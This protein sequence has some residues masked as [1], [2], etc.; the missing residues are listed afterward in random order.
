[1]GD[2]E[3]QLFVCGKNQNYELGFKDVN[4]IDTPLGMKGIKD[5]E[6]KEVSSGQNHSAIVTINGQVFMFG[7]NLHE[8]LGIDY[9]NVSN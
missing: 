2:R 3:S 5:Y 8:K 1:M 9:N 6:I 7:S 4:Y